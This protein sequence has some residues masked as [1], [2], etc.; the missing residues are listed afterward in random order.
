MNFKENSD[1]AHRIAMVRKLSTSDMNTVTKHEIKSGEVIR[2]QDVPTSERMK[3]RSSTCIIGN[4]E[5]PANPKE[6]GDIISEMVERRK[7]MIL[8]MDRQK[9]NLTDT[10]FPLKDRIQKLK[11]KTS[12]VLQTSGEQQLSTSRKPPLV[13]KPTQTV[14]RKTEKEGSYLQK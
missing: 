9:S 8:H 11:A 6:K 1:K 4:S 13:R 7:E 14:N 12:L 10:S 5:N 2:N 3:G